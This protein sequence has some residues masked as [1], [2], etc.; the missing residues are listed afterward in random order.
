MNGRNAGEGSEPFRLTPANAFTLL[1]VALAPLVIGL[2]LL[3]GRTAL[4][5]AFGVFVFAA[6]S[7]SVDGWVARRTSS[8]TQWGKLADPIADKILVLGCLAGL[9]WVGSLPWWAVAVIVLREVAV[10]VQRSVLSRRG[11]VMPASLFGK[12]KTVL[13]VVAVALYLLPGV[14][15]GVRLASLWIAVVVTVASGV[16]YAFRGARMIR[17]G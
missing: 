1:R 13:Q 4:W 8:V 17:A 12:V 9:A 6:L 11:V 10:T 2:L 7:D 16:E 5:W 15:E 3:G 14:A